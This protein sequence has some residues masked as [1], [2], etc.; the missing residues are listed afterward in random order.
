ML[1]Q[2][3]I[4]KRILANT[5]RSRSFQDIFSDSRER[6][7]FN[8]TY[9]IKG[10]FFYDFLRVSINTSVYR[11]LQVKWQVYLIQHLLELENCIPPDVVPIWAP[12][13]SPQLYTL[14]NDRCFF[15][16]ESMSALKDFLNVNSFLK[17][18]NYSTTILFGFN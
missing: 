11:Y 5:I 9:K 10:N 18:I 3:L 13:F 4:I 1:L 2:I 7:Y 14:L 16:I 12:R 15:V 6:P 17:F 8:L